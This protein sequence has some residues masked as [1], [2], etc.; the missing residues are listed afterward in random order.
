MYNKK[1]I[2]YRKKQYTKKKYNTQLCDNE[3]SFEDCEL[4]I[5]RHAVD[6]SNMI[7]GKKLVMNEDIKKIIEILENFIIRKKRMCYGGTAINNILPKDVQFYNRDIEIPDYDFYSPEALSDAKELADIYFQAGYKDVEAKSGMHHGTFKVFVN[8]IPIADISFM[9]KKIYNSI[10][11]E[12]IVIAGIHYSPPNFLRMGMYLE[13]S[14]PQGDVSRW[15]KVMKRLNLLNTYYPFNV[16]K[17]E[18]ID[19]QREMDVRKE[20]SEK[21]YLI[22]RNSF[23]DQN[24]VFFGGYASSLYSRYMPMEQQRI[25]R[26]IPDFDVLSEDYEKCG[27][28]VKEQLNQQGFN[29]IKI[30]KYSAIGEII[31]E[32]IQLMVGKDTIAFIYKPIACH[33]Y[34]TITVSNREIRIASIDTILSFYLA[35]IY[36]DFYSFYKERLLCM[37]KFIFDVEL[38]NR[39]EQKGLLKRFSVECYGKQKTLEDIRNEK[40]QKYKELMDKRNTEEYETWFLKYVPET[41]KEEETYQKMEKAVKNRQKKG[42]KRNSKTMKKIP[43]KKPIIKNIFMKTNESNAIL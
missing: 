16:D 36:S 18:T 22:V 11:N 21:I 31:P 6:D 29:N 32:H 14:R 33:S 25:I 34:N 42:K 43:K 9:N 4:A 19:F 37:A 20:D 40:S 24:V 1:H 2:F 41:K 35:F 39:L 3:M 10:L 27:A 38:K 15:E 26:K 30:V 28:I 7:T 23:I 8:F 17:C 12:S 13:L 5:L